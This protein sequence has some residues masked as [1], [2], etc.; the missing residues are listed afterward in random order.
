M[1]DA[2]MNEHTREAFLADLHV[3]VLAVERTDG[4]PLVSP[5]WYLYSR[6]GDVMVLTENDTLKARLLRAAGRAS[7]CVQREEA[8][9]A[10]VTVEGPVRFEKSDMDTRI[11]MA[12]RY[13]GPEGGRRFLQDT[14]ADMELLVRLTPHRWFSTD[15]SGLS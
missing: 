9:Y 13:L 8:P 6:G 4:P 12:T 11:A 1:A 14:S 3:G 10:Y 15:Y 5:V 2:R 7:L